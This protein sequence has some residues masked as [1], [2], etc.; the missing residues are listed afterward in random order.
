MSTGIGDP[1]QQLQNL[2]N[3]GNVINNVNFNYQQMINA[4]RPSNSN[5]VNHG[6]TI[7]FLG[8]LDKFKMTRNIKSYKI[9][10]ACFSV[11][12]LD[13]A[14]EMDALQLVL[15]PKHRLLLNK[16]FIDDRKMQ[17]NLRKISIVIH[18]ETYQLLT[19]AQLFGYLMSIKNELLHNGENIVDVIE[20]EW[21]NIPSIMNNQ[22]NFMDLADTNESPHQLF[23][24]SKE[25]DYHVNQMVVQ[26]NDCDFSL[27]SFGIMYQNIFHWLHRVFNHPS[28]NI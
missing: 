8:N 15:Q 13:F 28:C 12:T 21:K 20:I 10:F 23:G 9:H 22:G 17:P 4:M 25:I 2:N 14:H 19:L 27:K 6:A 1:S 7:R 5:I 24:F 18:N 3:F 11:N 16:L 26:W